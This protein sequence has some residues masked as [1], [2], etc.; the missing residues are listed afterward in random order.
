MENTSGTVSHSPG[1]HVPEGGIPDHVNADG[2]CPTPPSVASEEPPNVVRET[3]VQSTDAESTSGLSDASELDCPICYQSYCEPVLAGCSRHVFCRHCLWRAQRRGGPPQCPI[4]RAASPRDAA[5]LEEVTGLVE[6][7]RVKDPAY[8]ER[9][10]SAQ[11]E[12]EKYTSG[13]ARALLRELNPLPGEIWQFEVQGAGFVAA[14]GMYSVD[15]LPTYLGPTVYRKPDTNLF[16]FRWH[17]TQW[18]I[19][20]LRSQGLMGNERA[21]LYAAPT[22]APAHLPPSA[23]WAVPRRGCGYPPAPEVR[24]IC[25]HVGQFVQGRFTSTQWAASLSEP[26]AAEPPRDAVR[27]VSPP[28]RSLCMPP[29]NVM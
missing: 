18:V 12:R 27:G 23:G 28:R 10:V 4:C 17:R 25:R 16:M 7:L 20:D 1:V 3:G 15:V 11:R 26:T 21:W 19:A 9:A 8:Q 5:E 14:N 13:L 24:P 2:D 6:I 22:V 29:C